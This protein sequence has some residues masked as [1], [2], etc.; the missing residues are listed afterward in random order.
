MHRTF[1]KSR[2]KKTIRPYEYLINNGQYS[3]AAY[4]YIF[5][6][7]GIFVCE[8]KVGHIESLYFVLKNG[9]AKGVSLRTA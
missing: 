6:L 4:L 5:I 8:G 9:V 2:D 3:Q 1:F 7:S